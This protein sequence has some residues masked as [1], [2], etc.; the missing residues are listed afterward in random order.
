M[1]ED[2]TAWLRFLKLG[3]NYWNFQNLSPSYLVPE[4]FKEN[5]RWDEIQVFCGIS[6]Q[7]LSGS[8]SSSSDGLAGF[9]KVDMLGVWYTSV[10]FGAEKSLVS[11]NW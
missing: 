4:H 11:P 7:A 10:N 6:L 8:S 1:L 2:W 9:S 5:F 3:G